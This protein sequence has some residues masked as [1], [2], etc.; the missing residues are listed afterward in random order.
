VLN[1]AEGGVTKIYNRWS[2]GPEKRIALEAWAQ[3]LGGIVGSTNVVSFGAQP[4]AS[5]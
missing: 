4:G 1:H 5:R 2:Y 3:K